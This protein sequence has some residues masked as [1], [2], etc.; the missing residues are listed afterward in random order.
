M[1]TVQTWRQKRRVCVHACV[2]GLSRGV[3]VYEE[4]WTEVNWSERGGGVSC[5]DDAVWVTAQL[6]MVEMNNC[7]GDGNQSVTDCCH[8]MNVAET[9]CWNQNGRWS[10]KNKSPILVQQLEEK[11]L[12]QKQCYKLS[13]NI[14]FQLDLKPNN[15]LIWDCKCAFPKT[16][17]Q[18]EFLPLQ[19][20]LHVIRYL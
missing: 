7:R 1:R 14:L 11:K 5:C 6:L 4:K 13:T 18:I 17:Q 9:N 10:N 2:H 3:D 16:K 8:W 19:V 12:E 20:I 15:N